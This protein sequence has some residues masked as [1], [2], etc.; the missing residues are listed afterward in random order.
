MFDTKLQTPIDAKVL[1]KAKAKAKK[2]GFSSVN[3]VVRIVLR[4]YAEN[5]IDF[6]MIYN[7][8]IIH[9]YDNEKETK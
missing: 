3:E 7:S 1:K 2:R 8:D 5:K 6:E 9:G 4:L